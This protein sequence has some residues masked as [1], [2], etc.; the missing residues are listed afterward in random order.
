ME[1]VKIHGL[2]ELNRKLKALPDKIRKNSLR[3][4]A[5][6]GA[7]IVRDEAKRTVPPVRRTGTLRRAAYTKY[8]NRNSNANQVVYIVSFRRGKNQQSVGKKKLNRDAFYASWV[9]FGH[10]IVP[11]SKKIGMRKGKNAYEKTI[12][13]RRSAATGFVPGRK[14]L[15]RAFA[16]KSR[17]AL[18]ALIA[19]LREGIARL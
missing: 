4:A 11:R 8:L 1:T 6:A 2:D 5:N 17:Q 12:R 18:D 3:R 7:A 9:E 13:S 16:A 10:R 14:M 15:T 19:K